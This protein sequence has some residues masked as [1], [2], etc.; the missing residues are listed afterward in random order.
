[1]C[2][3][4]CACVRARVCVFLHACM[5]QCLVIWASR[6]PDHLDS[7]C[8]LCCTSVQLWRWGVYLS[9]ELGGGGLSDTLCC[10]LSNISPPFEGV[11]VSACL[12]VNWALSCASYPYHS[13]RFW[14][15][16]HVVGMLRFMSDIN[17]PSLPILFV[18]FLCLFLALWPVNCFSFHKFS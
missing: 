13:H 6:L 10:S 18:L 16:L 7:M 15:H 1:M 14:A 9:L 17:Q 12:S 2:V 5:C 8:C 3:C 11:L 4:V